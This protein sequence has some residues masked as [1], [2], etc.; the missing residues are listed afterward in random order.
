MLYNKYNTNVPKEKLYTSFLRMVSLVAFGRS[1]LALSS[2]FRDN[3]LSPA[4]SPHKTES[5]FAFK[6]KLKCL[7]LYSKLTNE[8][9][10]VPLDVKTNHCLTNIMGVAMRQV[11]PGVTGITGYIINW[12]E[13]SYFHWLQR[14]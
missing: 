4:Q 3:G 13:L 12:F 9:F 5:I 8:D 2:I 7:S 1:T 6:V 11:I 14:S 10:L